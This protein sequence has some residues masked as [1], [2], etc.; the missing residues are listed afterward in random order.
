VK[1]PPNVF[2]TSKQETPYVDLLSQAGGFCTLAY[3]FFDFT[4]HQLH[5][6]F[7]KMSLEWA[8]EPINDNRKS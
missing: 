8:E 1:V 4:K 3:R 7:K 5:L 6:F 2:E